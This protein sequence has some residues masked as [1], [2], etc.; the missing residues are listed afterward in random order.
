LT[1]FHRG[2]SYGRPTSVSGMQVRGHN[3]SELRITVLTSCNSCLICQIY[4]LDNGCCISGS[5]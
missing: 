1:S 5:R 2:S 3:L 4:D